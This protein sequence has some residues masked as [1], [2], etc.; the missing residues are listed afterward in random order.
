MPEVNGAIDAVLQQKLLDMYRR[1]CEAAEQELQHQRNRQVSDMQAKLA[2]RK[3][4]R[5]A[6]AQR[7]S[8]EEA[9]QRFLEEQERQIRMAVAHKE[10]DDTFKAPEVKYGES[11]E[12][13]ALMKEQVCA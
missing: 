3:A 6:E 5:L 4:R 2:A 12:E 1:D 13:K 7:K 11:T 8:E 9:A 10:T